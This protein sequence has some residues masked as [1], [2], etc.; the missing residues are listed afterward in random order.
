[1]F[2]AVRGN[3]VFLPTARAEK[4]VSIYVRRFCW[5]KVLRLMLTYSCVCMNVGT[6]MYAS[7]HVFTHAL[8]WSVNVS[9]CNGG[10][11]SMH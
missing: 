7:T 4:A 2:T 10:A 8:L 5:G 6:C 9:V 11:G 1:V 3:S